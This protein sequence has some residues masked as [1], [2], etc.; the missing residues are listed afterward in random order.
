VEGSDLGSDA[1]DTRALAWGDVDGD[2]DLDLIVGNSLQTSRLYLNNGTAYPF[3]GVTGRDVSSDTHNTRAL[4]LGDVD[5]DGDLDLIAGNIGQPNRL[6]LNNGTADP[7]NGVTG[8][9]VT[10]DGDNT[11]ALAL[12]DVDGDGDLDLIAGNN[13]TVNRLYLNNGTADP[14]SGV[15][16]VDVSGDTDAVRALALG[17]VDGDGDL[18][19]IVGNSGSTN[20]L[21]LNNGTADPW[22]G[23]TGSDVTS[24]SHETFA[25]ALGDVDRDGDLDL[26]AGNSGQT[27][28]FYPNNGTADPWNGVTAMDVSGDAHD[29]L[30]LALGDVDG[31]GD[32]DLIA[33]NNGTANRFY[34]NNGSA[35]PWLDVAGSDVHS[36]THRTYTLALGDVD[37]DG[38]LDLIAGNNEQANRLY[39]RRLYDTS[40]GWAGSV[41]VDG[42]VSNIDNATLTPTASLPQHTSVAYWLSNNGGAKWYLVQPGVNFTFPTS[43]IDLRWRAELGSLSPIHTPRIDSIVLTTE[44]PEVSVAVAPASLAEDD[45]GTL[46]YT[47]TRT[48]ALT[49]TLTINF[50]VDGTALFETDYTQSGAASFNATGGTV[51][52]A[53]GNATATVTI[54][55]IADTASENDETVIL[56]V[57][58]GTGY[59]VGSPAAA[60]GTI[61]DDDAEPTST[62]TS[63]PM[64]T[65]TSTPTATPTATPTGTTDNGIW[66]PLV[67]R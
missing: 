30:A 9:D 16:G 50:S 39:Q 48:D 52:M 53:A 36:D 33:G 54:D 7:W 23:V 57:N 11:E 65:P 49:D 10:S 15:T 42:E 35:D 56:T 21:Y 24:D 32:L 4:A 44:R 62:P 17:D 20:R 2:G 28:R 22:N 26:I 1:H 60:T 37:G 40:R 63:T 58:V 19:L 27:N 61:T 25:L 5:G 66:L 18:D 31:D 14:W 51:T 38:H 12:G 13:G 34:L 67:E 47:F 46:I 6:Y 3:A 59:I 45:T 43:G 64:S 55:P 41:R 29:T 8:V